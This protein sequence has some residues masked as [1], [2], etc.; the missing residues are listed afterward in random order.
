MAVLVACYGAGTAFFNPA[1]D[2][3]VP[4]V[5]PA[6][7][8]VRANSLDQFVRPLAL[9]LA[10]P[11]L[12]GVLIASVGAGGAFALDAASFAFSACAVL[13]M[14]ARRP[15]AAAGERLGAEVRA[16]LRYVRSQAWVW[17]TLV[18]AA[19]AYLLFMGPV[20]VLLPFVVKNSLH[21]D[22]TD[23]G[24]VFAAG[25]AGSVG[26]ALMIGRRGLPRRDITFM[27]A[28]WTLATL[29]VA[30]Y[31]LSTALWHLMLASVLFNALETAG[32]IVWAT[33]KQRHVPPAML[34]RVSSLDWLVSTA[35]LPLSFALTGPAS[36]ALGAQGTLVAAGALGALVTVAGL[37]VP[38]V[39]AVEGRSRPFAARGKPLP[40]ALRSDP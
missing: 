17:A 37:L 38:G 26:C 25:G 32:T 24:L 10:G 22:A 2:A 15:A 36:A 33:A 21:G 40:G 23:L 3:I 1:F 12:G 8:L 28:A 14:A 27:Y 30:G 11:A 19:L 18:A 6:A 7:E 31:G 35:L 13:A 20:E 5:L 4:D 34:G 9:R 29:A 16:G 39:R